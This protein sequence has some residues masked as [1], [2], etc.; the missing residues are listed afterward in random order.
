MGIRGK[1]PSITRAYRYAA[2]VS[3]GTGDL[4]VIL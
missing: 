2:G 3:S 4:S 1:H